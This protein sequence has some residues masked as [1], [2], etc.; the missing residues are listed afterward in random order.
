MSG[1][2]WYFKFRFLTDC[3][4]WTS[5]TNLGSSAIFQ[6]PTTNNIGIGISTP[7]TKLDVNG[8]AFIRGALK[9]AGNGLNVVLGNVGC[10]SPTW[11]I[12]AAG[13]NCNTF[14]WYNSAQP[15]TYINRPREEQSISARTMVPTR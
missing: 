12:G 6:N 15:A 10:S 3:A 7:T 14:F 9:S 11:G 4:R 8:G 13:V 1:R 5:S 2:I